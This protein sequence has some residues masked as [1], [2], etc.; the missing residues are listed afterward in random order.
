M[1]RPLCCGRGQT[2]R[3]LVT[4]AREFLKAAQLIANQVGADDLT[5]GL[6]ENAYHNPFYHLCGH[7]LELSMKATLL[8]VGRTHD[9]LRRIGHDLDRC[10]SEMRKLYPAHNYDEHAG[11]IALLN[12]SYLEKKFEYRITGAGR[13]PHVFPL[14]Y[15]VEE[16]SIWADEIVH[17]AGKKKS[18]AVTHEPE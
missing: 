4:H 11:L 1:Q 17:D 13:W 9:E 6:R 10:L 14:L 5:G 15:V 16:F 12:Q 3:G 2:P 8:A 18:L 7:S